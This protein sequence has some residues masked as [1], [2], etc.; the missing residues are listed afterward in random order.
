MNT[1]NIKFEQRLII[2]SNE[3][4]RENQLSIV[5]LEAKSPYWTFPRFIKT[6]KAYLKG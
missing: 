1:Q 3:V 6:F 2:Q 4:D 5:P